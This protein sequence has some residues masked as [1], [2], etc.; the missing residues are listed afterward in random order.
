MPFEARYRVY[1]SETNVARITHILSILSIVE[2]AE[3]GL[4]KSVDLH[5]IH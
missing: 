3:E 4:Y 1:W 5:D 2:R